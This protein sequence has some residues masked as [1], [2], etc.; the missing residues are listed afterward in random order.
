ME[1]RPIRQPGLARGRGRRFGR[2]RRPRDH[3][4][5]YAGRMHAFWLDKTEHGNCPYSIYN[6]AEGFCRFA[7]EAVV[8]DLENDGYSE[9]IFSS[10]AQKGSD[11][12]GKLHVLDHLGRSLTPAVSQPMSSASS[13]PQ[14][15]YLSYRA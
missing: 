13:P 6:A 5:D 11:Q 7:S 1:H 10:W 12:A 8:S 4:P 9:V 15:R 14:Q 3:L 2:G